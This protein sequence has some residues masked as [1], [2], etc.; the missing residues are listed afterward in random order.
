[1]ATVCHLFTEF[2][3]PVVL[4]AQSFFGRLIQIGCQ[5]KSKLKRLSFRI[6]EFGTASTQAQL[7][8]LLLVAAEAAK[9]LPRIRTIEIWNTLPKCAYIFCYSLEPYRCKIT[10]TSAGDEFRLSRRVVEAWSTAPPTGTLLTVE[11]KRLFKRVRERGLWVNGE[12]F[13]Q[14]LELRHFVYGPVTLAQIEATAATN[15]EANPG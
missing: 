10:W 11:R 7:D 15:V 1:M 13:L 9:M 8:N 3:T 6:G 5:E 14:H 12:S 2:S 4:I